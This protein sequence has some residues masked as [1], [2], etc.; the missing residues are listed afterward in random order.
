MTDV[1]LCHNSTD[2][3]PVEYI[4][5]RLKQ[6]G[7]SVWLDTFNLIPGER[8]TDEI[9]KAL[10]KCNAIAVFIGQ[11]G[12]G[13][14]QN[15]ELNRAMNLGVEKGVP[16]I[17]VLLPGAAPEMISG[18]LKDI[19]RVQFE[20]SLDET[21]PFGMLV[22]GIRKIPPSD[23]VLKFEGS[24]PLDSDGGPRPTE[25]PYRPLAAFDVADHL[26]FYGRDGITTKTVDRIEAILSAST[27]CFSIIGASGSGK[28]SLARAGVV[29]SI[30]QNHPDWL[31]VILQPG[32]RP[33]ETLA[34]RMLKLT[35]DQV[36][37][38]ILKAHGEAYLSDAAMLQRSIVGAVGSDASK[39]RVFILVDQFE[40]VFTVCET[41]SAR[42]AFIANL[43]DAARD[44]SGKVVVLLCMRAD[45]Y[46]NCAKTELA[47]VVSNAQILVGPLQ[48]DELR[49]AIQEPAARAGCQVEPALVASLVK[50][51]EEQPS[52]LPLLEI[53]LEKLW[54]KRDPQRRLTLAEYDK[55]SLAG[56]ID[57]HADA[58]FDKLLEPQK[59]T[60]RS[61]M[62]QLTEPLDDGRF[63]RRRVPVDSLLPPTDRNREKSFVR[64][65]QVETVLGILSGQS[66]RLITLRLE[67]SVAKV[68]VSHE[69]I[70]RGWKR[71]ASWL[72]KDREF[73]VWKRRLAFDVADWKTS[74]RRDSYLTG[75]VLDRARTWLSERPDDH[76]QEER[77]F[78]EDSSLR[79]MIRRGSVTA[80]F[81][82][83]VV[84]AGTAVYWLENKQKIDRTL[85]A[86]DKQLE[87]LE[88][89]ADLALLLAYDA[90][91]REKSPRTREMLQRA[92]QYAGR[93][94]LLQD[95]GVT[96]LCFSQGGNVLA[97]DSKSIKIWSPVSNG[98][99]KWDPSRL[100]PPKE[101]AFQGDNTKIAASQDNKLIVAG[102]DKGNVAIWRD[103]EPVIGAPVLPDS[104]IRALS[105]S[106]DGHLAI[107][108]DK[109]ELIWWSSAKAKQE[110]R[111]STAQ[112]AWSVAI[113]LDS[114]GPTVAVGMLG[115]VRFW[116]P[117]SGWHDGLHDDG[118]PMN[119]VTSLAYSNNGAI[120]ASSTNQGSAFRW[121]ANQPSRSTRVAV[122]EGKVRSLAMDASGQHFAVLTTEDSI[123]IFSAESAGP[124][125]FIK[126][127]PRIKDTNGAQDSTRKADKVAMNADGTIIA[128]AAADGIRIYELRDDAV[129][130]LARIYIRDS[131]I[132][133]QICE[134]AEQIGLK[135]SN[136][137]QDL[138]ESK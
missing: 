59:A 67:G 89:R 25:C 83:I 113:S 8:F 76:T 43:L 98:E 52:P 69:V 23:V 55:M 53:A 39:G 20:K 71:L 115:F 47:E 86:A 34:E 45:F 1:F 50:D 106:N 134:Q 109:S 72:D 26:Y 4:A 118:K 112:K 102:N 58:V 78:V 82:T 15:Q 17:P 12:R 107:A 66:A 44:S 68:E 129:A 91:K 128:T 111:V 119:P 29:W 108:T 81:L 127:E 96:D 63:S 79:R 130:A 10:D 41:E 13:P 35:R 80:A 32:A 104:K 19:S 105:V 85:T 18:F 3:G 95:H 31:T 42:K 56:A 33:H 46:E 131:Q 123:Y 21:K 92:V 126:D 11:S 2:S 61:L 137:E 60:C 122:E 138:K 77:R 14:Y 27:R 51:C 62:L 30:Q 133:R 5:N 99:I 70:F 64:V 97:A 117:S 90:A 120:I 28:S 40:E 6:E 94:P 121:Y 93:G 22:A 100:A 75:G 65:K 84:I 136:C 49:S 103:S 114:L 101:L 73:L 16:T 54:Q 116:N 87:Q 37:A 9:Q 125:M 38:L 110:A 36:D 88:P 7:I 48:R 124:E 135:K 57:E 24:A 74:K 132:D